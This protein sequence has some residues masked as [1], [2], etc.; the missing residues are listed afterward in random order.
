ML[1]TSVTRVERYRSLGLIKALQNLFGNI[2]KPPLSYGILKACYRCNYARIQEPVLV[3]SMMRGPRVI[4]NYKGKT[5]VRRGKC[6]GFKD[7]GFCFKQI[8]E[9]EEDI[10]CKW[11]EI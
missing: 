10:V 11:K 9:P 3:I 2:K 5:Y 1:L 6:I 4:V 8:E 7:C